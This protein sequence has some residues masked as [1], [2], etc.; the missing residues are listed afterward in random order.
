MSQVFSSV[1]VTQVN[2]VIVARAV[3]LSTVAV[4]EGVKY[5]EAVVAVELEGPLV[6]IRVVILLCGV[7]LYV[8]EEFMGEWT[9]VDHFLV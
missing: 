5:M 6:I 8:F 7:L 4:L 3:S 9:I 1:L 2:V